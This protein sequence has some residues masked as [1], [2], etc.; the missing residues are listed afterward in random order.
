M[1]P[2]DQATG[3]P[4]HP[5]FQQGVMPPNGQA[6]FPYPQPMMPYGAPPYGGMP[7]GAVPAGGDWSAYI[8][9]DQRQALQALSPRLAPASPRLQDQVP[10]PFQSAPAPVI[11]DPAADPKAQ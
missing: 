9:P 4:P 3:A 6:H 10:A 7:Y 11:A 5:W 8:P 1:P 2:Y